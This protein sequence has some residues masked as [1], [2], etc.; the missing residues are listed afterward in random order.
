[1]HE[2]P[3][4]YA[5]TVAMLRAHTP[6]IANPYPHTPMPNRNPQPNPTPNRGRGVG[7]DARPTREEPARGG[8]LS[9]GL[10][11]NGLRVGG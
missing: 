7:A 5:P 8:R 4:R 9:P 2:T 3:H 1:M 10:A 11:T 6:L